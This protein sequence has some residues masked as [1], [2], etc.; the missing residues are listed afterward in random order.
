M[1]C[2]TERMDIVALLAELVAA[3]RKADPWRIVLFGSQANGTA[4]PDSDIDI[5]VILDN[6]DVAQTYTERLQKELFIRTLVYE[7]NRKVALDILVYS[8]AE[9]RKVKAYGNF[10]VEEVEKTG[11]VIYEKDH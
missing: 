8:R 6:E 3:L 4:R 5:M 11:K 2:Y 1:L 10:F 7:V 9:Y